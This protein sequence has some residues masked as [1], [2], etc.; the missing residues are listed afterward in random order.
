MRQRRE[1]GLDK[2]DL[3][4]EAAFRDMVTEMFDLYAATPT[5]LVGDD[6]DDTIRMW[7]LSPLAL[8]WF[9]RLVEGV[10]LR[11]VWYDVVSRRVMDDAATPEAGEARLSVMRRALWMR[12]A[13]ISIYIS[14]LIEELE[15]RNMYRFAPLISDPKSQKDFKDAVLF[16]LCDPDTDQQMEWAGDGQD[17]SF[18][19]PPPY[20]NLAYGMGLYP[21]EE[22]TQRCM[23]AWAAFNFA[24]ACVEATISKPSDLPAPV[25]VHPRTH[26]PEATSYMGSL[27]MCDPMIASAVSRAARGVLRIA[28]VMGN[29]MWWGFYFSVGLIR[30]LNLTHVDHMMRESREAHL[31]WRKSALNNGQYH[32]D[33]H[34]I[35]QMAARVIWTDHGGVA[36]Q[37]SPHPY[38][39]RDEDRARLEAHLT[40]GAFSR[41]CSVTFAKRYQETSKRITFAEDTMALATYLHRPMMEAQALFDHVFGS[42]PATAKELR[43]RVTSVVFGQVAE[44]ND[45][46]RLLPGF[47]A[48]TR[49][50]NARDPSQLS[51]F[52]GRDYAR[53]PLSFPLKEAIQAFSLSTPHELMLKAH[54]RFD[55]DDEVYLAAEAMSVE[56]WSD[57][58]FTGKHTESDGAGAAGSESD[59]AGA[60]AHTVVAHIQ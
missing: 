22:K 21:C 10:T 19:E 1:P 44:R 24:R 50:E 28:D 5:G 31:E 52:L 58:S 59:G 53:S 48:L 30:D 29:A 18:S 57:A 39:L 49:G 27:L 38:L 42:D 36:T 13:S 11:N 55:E 34:A 2:D 56:E 26:S 8:L 51:R 14:R 60:A 43:V 47:H 6:N 35:M 41:M 4:H 16:L 3:P 45:V 54:C 46:R 15:I 7:D 25:W 12:L 17:Y 37:C 32:G 40:P 20:A 33:V 9:V 23:T